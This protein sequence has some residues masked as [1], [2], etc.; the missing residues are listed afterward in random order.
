MRSFEAKLEAGGE[1]DAWVLIT[2]PFD[3][4]A[5]FGSAG[6][7]SVHGD[8]NGVPFASSLY[9]RGDGAHQLMVNKTMQKA[10]RAGPG[11]IAVVHL[12]AGDGPEPALAPDLAA[13]LEDEPMCL[14]GTP[15]SLRPAAANMWAGSIRRSG[16]RPAPSGSRRQS[17]A[18]P[19]A[20]G[21]PRR[22]SPFTLPVA[23]RLCAVYKTAMATT[24]EELEKRRAQARLGGGEKRIAAQ[25]AKG[26]LTAR[27]R[28]TVLLD[29]GAFE[30]YDMYVEHNC[31]DFGMETQKVPGDGVV[32]GSGTIN[33]RLV[34]RLR[35]GF[36]RLRRLA[37]R[38]PRRRRSAR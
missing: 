16:P 20:N 32:T 21:A 3:V 12:A 29:P 34:Y 25:H 2:I 5:A 17:R 22:N 1:G 31:V 10:A 38:A 4:A 19:P 28:L 26:R 23:Q 27:E 37:L 6:R 15:R 24:I 36:H 11:D 8:I 14:L 33:G 13:A 7:V 30:E 9:P 35:P 18:S